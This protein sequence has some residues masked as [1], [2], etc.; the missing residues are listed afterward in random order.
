VADIQPSKPFVTDSPLIS[1]PFASVSLINTVE[2]CEK[3][4]TGERSRIKMIVFM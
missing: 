3:P 4:K 1:W 2:V